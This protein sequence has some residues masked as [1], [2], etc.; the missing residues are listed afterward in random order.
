[1]TLAGI[2]WYLAAVVA[3]SA[4]TL[5]PI[6]LVG[7]AAPDVAL[8]LAFVAMLAAPV[9]VALATDAIRERFSG[10]GGGASE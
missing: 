7:Q 6:L 5:V 3:Y 9:P 1:M 10:G 8:W 2:C 4:V